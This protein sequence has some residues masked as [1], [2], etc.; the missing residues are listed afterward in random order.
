MKDGF[1]FILGNNLFWILS[2]AIKFSR[3]C[4]DNLA[5]NGRTCP[6]CGANLFLEYKQKNL[7]IPEVL[8]ICQKINSL[9][10]SNSEGKG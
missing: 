1:Y 9:I 7:K 10:N 4:A 5:N 2:P 6:Q 8:S 3:G